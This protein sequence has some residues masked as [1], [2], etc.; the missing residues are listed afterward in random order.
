MNVAEFILSVVRKLGTDTTFSLTGGMAMHINRAAA[1]SGMQVVYCNHEQAVAAAA[2]GYAKAK[3]FKIPGLAVVTSGPAVMNITNSVASAYYDSVPVF[4][5]AGQIKTADINA[6]GVRSR[7]AQETPHLEVMKPL[8]KCAFRYVPD[9]VSD[10]ALAS[11]MSQ[12]IAGRK[13]PVFI[14]IPL[15][16]QPLTVDNAEARLEVIVKKIHSIVDT[17]ATTVGEAAKII[18]QELPKAARPVIVIGN[19]LHIAGISRE[20]VRRLVEGLGIPALFTWPSSDLLE[21]AHDLNFG[22]AGGLAP[23]HANKIIQNADLLIFL[24]VRLDLLTTAF[25]PQNYGKRAQRIIVECD[26]K[27]ID[28]NA[29]IQNARFF[30]ENLLNV[31]DALEKSLPIATAADWLKTCHDW[32]DEDRREEEKAFA[33]QGLTTYQMAKTLSESPAARYIVP[34]GS[35]FAIEGFARF[36]R[37]QKDGSVAW[38]GHCLGSMGLALPMAIGAAAALHQPVICLE[39][40]GGILLNVQELFTLAAHPQLPLTI[41]VM[42]NG[43]YQSI[44]KSQNRVFGKEFG[45]SNKSGLCDARFDLLAATVGLP[46]TKCETVAQFKETMARP[47]PSGRGLIELILAED[48]YRGPAVATKFDA[49]GKPYS[50]DIGDVTWERQ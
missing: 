15:D 23:T 22:C 43:G 46:Y 11:N 27:E 1:E 45:A 33:G 4:I 5:L 42:N 50:T 17:E 25:N 29:A 30:R 31:V 34:T 38:A 14:E 37:P 39:G 24:G 2:D 3:E 21:H 16:V 19:G 26:Q 9:Q 18:A 36:F 35:G 10:E 47:N 12:A 6:F 28:K 49:N 40:D 32:R 20:R 41:I 48:G 13:G 8:T 44:V 7:G